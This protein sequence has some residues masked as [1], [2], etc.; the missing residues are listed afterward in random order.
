MIKTSSP[1]LPYANATIEIPKVS[2]GEGSDRY[3]NRVV[4]T[5]TISYQC[6]LYETKSDIIETTNLPGVNS[7]FIFLSGYLIDPYFLPTN[8]DFPCD[9][10]AEVTIIPGD[11]RHGKMRVAPVF[12][13]PFL[14]QA[15]YKYLNRVKGW[16]YY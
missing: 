11:V 1:F 14:S 2:V 3:G 13:D 16:F 6:I 7:H 12:S 9:C 15:G 10:E 4:I 5:E 8:I